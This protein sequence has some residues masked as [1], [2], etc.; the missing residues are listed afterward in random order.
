[1]L[2]RTLLQA[3]ALVLWAWWFSSGQKR[4]TK[5]TTEQA[6]SWLAPLGPTENAFSGD[7]DSEFSLSVRARRF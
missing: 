6:F 3:E 7:E 4:L 1:M 5:A 2:D